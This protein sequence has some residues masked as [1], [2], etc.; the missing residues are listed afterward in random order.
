MTQI[1]NRATSTYFSKTFSDLSPEISSVFG[2]A[3]GRDLCR[4][5]ASDPNL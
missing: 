4:V 1:R 5:S 2:A 3:G